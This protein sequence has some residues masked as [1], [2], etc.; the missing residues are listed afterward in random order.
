MRDKGR[1][2]TEH[3]K[4]TAADVALIRELYIPYDRVYGGPALARQFGVNRRYITRL[5]QQ[6]HVH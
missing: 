5:V 4:L 1:Q 6:T 2:S 3:G